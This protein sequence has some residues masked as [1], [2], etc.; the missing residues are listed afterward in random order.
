MVNSVS[1]NSKSS[2]HIDNDVT[3]DNSLQQE[4]RLI[5]PD[6]ALDTENEFETA[7]SYLEGEMAENSINN[8]DSWISLN[9]SDSC[10][11][12]LRSSS[13]TLLPPEMF[14]VGAN[15]N[16]NLFNTILMN[17]IFM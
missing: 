16:V 7:I 6:N 4:S 9:D 5:D 3:H 11:A 2:K 15:K 10:T 14:G 8:Y 12:I 13:K 1:H 17:N